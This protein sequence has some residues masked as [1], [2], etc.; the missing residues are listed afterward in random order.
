[1]AP[2]DESVQVEDA[3]LGSPRD[4]CGPASQGPGAG[5]NPL[6]VTQLQQQMAQTQ[7]ILQQH[8]TENTRLQQELGSIEMSN[9]VQRLDRQRRDFEATLRL[10]TTKLALQAGLAPASEGAPGPDSV[11]HHRLGMT[12]PGDVVGDAARMP[13]PAVDLSTVP[14]DSELYR[15]EMEHRT[16]LLRVRYEREINA[17]QL[18]L[19]N[20]KQQSEMK[21]RENEEQRRH[22][23]ALADLRRQL[24]KQR[25]RQEL[26]MQLVTPG[27]ST[28]ALSAWTHRTSRL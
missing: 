25:L 11:Q 8:Q 10:M 5:V 13:A 22:E 27:P 14:K 21:A 26:A 15:L 20:V 4:N 2:V 19:A 7:L 24:E 3:S 9:E 16:R 1:M 17:E 28:F 18:E 23:Q 12:F 6:L